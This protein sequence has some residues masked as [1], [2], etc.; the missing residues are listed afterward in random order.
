MDTEDKGA[1]VRRPDEAVQHSLTERYTPPFKAVGV[2]V[3]DL[4]GQVVCVAGS[5][6]QRVTVREVIATTIARCLNATDC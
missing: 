4:I 1:L 5:V 2:S 3:C 6:N